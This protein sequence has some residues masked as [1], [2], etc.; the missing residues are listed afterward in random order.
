M[1]IQYHFDCPLYGG[2]CFQRNRMGTCKHQGIPPLE[3]GIEVQVIETGMLPQEG[4]TAIDVSVYRE[5][6]VQPDAGI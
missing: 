4:E 5:T 3:R 2:C 1:S 6:G